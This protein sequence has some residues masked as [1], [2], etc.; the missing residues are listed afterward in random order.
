MQASQVLSCTSGAA[1]ARD[2][3]RR[4]ET[5]SIVI[6][7]HDF[8][9][10]DFENSYYGYFPGYGSMPNLSNYEMGDSGYTWNNQV[11]ALYSTTYLKVFEEEG[12]EGDYANL[13][14]G[15]HDLAN[16]ASYGIEN[17]DI[18]SFYAVY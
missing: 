13:G 4:D 8:Y 9:D 17:D 1:R 10:D 5:T 11:S 15:F 18:A 16:L 14:S 12:H 7:Q 2:R 3:A 6:Y